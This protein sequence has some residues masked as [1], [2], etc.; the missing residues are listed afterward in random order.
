MTK[1]FKLH[2]PSLISSVV[3][4][5]LA[6]TSEAASE[7]SQ[8]NREALDATD[9]ERRSY[10]LYGQSD[11]ND[12]DSGLSVYRSYIYKTATAPVGGFGTRQGWRI[13]RTGLLSLQRY[14]I[15]DPAEMLGNPLLKGLPEGEYAIVVNEG[16]SAFRFRLESK[17]W[18]AADS[19]NENVLTVQVYTSGDSRWEMQGHRDWVTTFNEQGQLLERA[20]HGR[21]Y[22]YAYNS[23]GTLA[24]VQTLEGQTLTFDYDP[25]ARIASFTSHNNETTHYEYDNEGRLLAVINPDDTPELSDNPTEHYQYSDANHPFL[26]TGMVSPDAYLTLDARY[27]NATDELVLKSLSGKLQSSVVT[28]EVTNLE[29]N[30]SNG[31][32][33]GYI[34]GER[35]ATTEIGLELSDE[36]A[37]TAKIRQAEDAGHYVEHTRYTLEG[38]ACADCMINSERFYDRNWVVRTSEEQFA[39]GLLI[40]G[41]FIPREDQIEVSEP[42]VQLMTPIEF[43]SQRLLSR[44]ESHHGLL[45]KH[46]TWSGNP[47]NNVVVSEEEP[48]RTINY[49]H[50]ESGHRTSQTVTDT[51]KLTAIP[52]TTRYQYDGGRLVLIDGPRTDVN[53][54][55]Q[56][57]FDG[58]GNLI[59]ATNGLEQFT[60]FE[61]D[62]QNRRTASVDPNGLRTE[63]TYGVGDRI[64]SQTLAAGTGQ[65]V[66]THYQYD[67]D[68]NLTY[69]TLPSGQMITRE[70][71]A[72]GRVIKLSDQD[73]NHIDYKYDARGNLIEGAVY[74]SQQQSLVQIAQ[75]A[76]DN[77]GRVI[78]RGNDNMTY[79]YQGGSKAPTAITTGKGTNSQLQYDQYGRLSKST[80]AS[81]GETHYQYDAQGNTTQVIDARGVITNFEYNG[82]GERIAEHSPSKGTLTYQHDEAG[83]VTKE[84][85][86]NG[87]VI[88][89]Q[90]D[91]LNRLTKVL[92]KQKGQE[93]KRIKYKYDNCTNGIGKL[94]KVSGAGSTTRYDY[95]LHGNTSKVKTRLYDE[96]TANVTLY[97]YNQHNQLTKLIYPSGLKVRY[98]YNS[99]GFIT[100]ITAR[101]GNENYTIAEN[102]KYLP[103]QNGLSQITFGNGLTTELAYNQQ[104]QLTRI[105]TGDIQDFNYQYDK[106]GN[107]TDISHPLRDDWQQQF[108]YN[109]LNRLVRESQGMQILGYEYDDV[110]NRLVRTKK[111]E[112]EPGVK[113]KSYHYNKAANRLEKINN[114]ELTY[115]AN[116][117]LI[118]DKN[119]KRQF[120]YDVTNRLVRY[121]KNGEHKASYTYNAFGQRIK[122]TIMRA[123]KNDDDHKSL[124][125]TYLPNGWLLSE[126]SR[127]EVS[128]KVF[129]R[130]YIWL[131]GKPIAQI[132]SKFKVNGS[133]K[134]QTISYIHTDHL[135]T[136][137]IAT[138][139]SQEVV[140][141][142]DSDAFG[143]RKAENDPDQNGKKTK[144]GLRFAGQYFDSESG[145]HYNRYRDYDPKIGRYIQ[146]D[147]VGIAGGL[148]IYAYAE[149]NPVSLTDPLGLSPWITMATFRVMRNETVEGSWSAWMFEGATHIRL[150]GGAVGATLSCFWKR[151][152]STTY[153]TYQDIY[154][155]QTRESCSG[156]ETRNVLL[157]SDL[158]YSHSFDSSD[159]VTQQHATPLYLWSHNTGI[160]PDGLCQSRYHI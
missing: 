56:F 110:G 147:P 126:D 65:A 55:I 68:G 78:T 79:Q 92:F 64:L 26:L 53:D 27:D 2:L 130:D 85:R 115:D 38:A 106:N 46:T 127:D 148:S 25:A 150:T 93:K 117:N 94:C 80:D 158:A 23:D 17:E 11:Y 87:I 98:H 3:L 31:L 123:R 59:K 35:S 28:S 41:E 120:K 69:V 102:I 136:P 43:L 1:T 91:E 141:R 139:Q 104:G 18:K 5:V 39:N 154:E 42:L 145:L 128:H 160:R 54:T 14:T 97:E 73:G 82:F 24:S 109:D 30:W 58:E 124:T 10:Y 81:D 114:Q 40:K 134:S 22:S 84:T 74:D 132:K 119:G 48:G 95:D 44:H 138:D 131:G 71:D 61:Y 33:V 129:T 90:F 13:Q 37:I 7:P 156:F 103:M 4:S 51:T 76:F 15:S 149:G 8:I 62:G 88:K 155:V 153:N 107:L 75:Q 66:A 16:S 137:R 72:L 142:W 99:S 49:Q 118:E 152:K 29:Y 19:S 151:F 63:F 113:T 133:I 121:Y 67:V 111:T 12:S 105:D 144:I 157:T 125:F 89:R 159:R 122:K 101:Q 135:N 86:E 20:G 112:A 34:N 96:S 140:W 21:F 100:K 45:V 83:N 146:S 32:R 108:E 47:D 70:Y 57:N 116:G 50:D 6:V 36:D 9:E 60:Q 52:R 77:L 143:E